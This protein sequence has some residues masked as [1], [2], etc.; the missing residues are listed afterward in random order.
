[1]KAGWSHRQVKIVESLK[2][3]MKSSSAP[4]QCSNNALPMPIYSAIY[5]PNYYMFTAG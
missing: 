2:K 3:I 1:M 5:G 4:L